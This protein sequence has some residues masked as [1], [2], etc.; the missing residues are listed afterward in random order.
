MTWRALRG[1]LVV[2]RCEALEGVDQLGRLPPCQVGV[3]PLQ[4]ALRIKSGERHKAIC[5]T[6]PIDGAVGRGTLLHQHD[7]LAKLSLSSQRLTSGLRPRQ[8]SVALGLRQRCARRHNPLWVGTTSGSD[9]Y[10]WVSL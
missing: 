2:L 3:D 9:G 5:R 7:D 4:R 6:E 8:T 1:L 10:S